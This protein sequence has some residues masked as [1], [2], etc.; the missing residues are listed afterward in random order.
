MATEAQPVK[1][2]HIVSLLVS[3]VSSSMVADGA[4]RIRSRIEHHF[5]PLEKQESWQSGAVVMALGLLMLTLFL[6][7]FG[8]L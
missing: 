8:K 1:L 7:A 2:Q 5:W 4:S 6:W 3:I